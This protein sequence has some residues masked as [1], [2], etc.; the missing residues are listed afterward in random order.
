MSDAYDILRRSLVY[1]VWAL[2]SIASLSCADGT[3]QLDWSEVGRLIQN[4][5]P[6]VPSVTTAELVAALADGR[7]VVLLDVREAAEFAVSHLSGAQRVTSAVA[8]SEVLRSA[9]LGTLVVAY[10]SV[11]YRSAAL[12]KELQEQGVVNAVNLEGSIFAWANAG[13]PV[14]RGD[15]EVDEVH[16]FD[17]VWGALLDRGLLGIR[18][19][20]HDTVA[21]QPPRGESF[22]YLWGD[23]S[24]LRG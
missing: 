15:L 16:P 5:Y 8:A 14:Y 10:C 4:H 13:L 7:D 12:V 18:A 1:V 9:T 22:T 11:G 17:D 24:R 3:R 19:S 23:S 20:G 6:G 2:I 21:T